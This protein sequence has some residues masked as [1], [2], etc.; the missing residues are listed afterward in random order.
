M[1]ISIKTAVALLAAL[2]VGGSAQC[3]A[4]LSRCVAVA[5]EARWVEGVY[6]N[7]A[8]GYAIR[9]PRGLKGVTG[10]QS[11]PERGLRITL[12]LGG[13]IAIWGEPNSGDWKMPEEGI[14]FALA[15]ESCASGQPEVLRTRLGRLTAAKGSLVCNDRVLKLFLVIRPGG[16]LV[17]WLRLETFRA[18]ELGDSAILENIAATFQTIRW[19]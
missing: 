7:P 5:P 19:K 10:D 2:Q 14:R 18:Q 1:R 12:P 8:L 13:E 9:V 4:G 16:G 3:V 11:G 6:R 15:D 17:Y